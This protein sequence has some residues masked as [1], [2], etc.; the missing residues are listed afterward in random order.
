M[1][2]SEREKEEDEA[3]DDDMLEHGYL[4]RIKRIDATLHQHVSQY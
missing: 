4:L 2:E 3:E 1:R